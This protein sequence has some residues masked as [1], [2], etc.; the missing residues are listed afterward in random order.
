MGW[1]GLVGGGGGGVKGLQ[2]ARALLHAQGAVCG[3]ARSE[4]CND[5][6]RPSPPPQAPTD[7][8]TSIHHTHTHTYSRSMQVVVPLTYSGYTS[9]RVLTTEWLDGEKLSQSKVRLSVVVGWLGLVGRLL[10]VLWVGGGG[11]WFSS[12]KGTKSVVHF[13]SA[14]TPPPPP[15]PPPPHTRPINQP[16]APQPHTPNQPT[17]SH[18]N[19]THPINQP[20]TPRPM[21]WASW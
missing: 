5:C 4:R 14:A 11:G 6:V 1:D 18:P 21:T 15:P 10:W 3:P 9:R 16:L 13:C 2:L 20:P 19:H 8:P 12:L 7:Q 17:A